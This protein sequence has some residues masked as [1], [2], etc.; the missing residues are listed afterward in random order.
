MNDRTRKLL[1]DV[2][3]SGR[4]IREWCAGR[5]FED[6]CSDRKF[7]RAVER[8]FEIIGEALNR[9]SEEDSAIAAQIPELSRIIAFRNR[10]IHGYDSVDDAIVWGV[11]E[12]HLPRL[13]DHIEKLL[14]HEETW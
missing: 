9:L 1:H 3:D 10:I 6:Y 4:A 13:L 2:V 14:A 8:E 11:M 12:S 7:R 5:S